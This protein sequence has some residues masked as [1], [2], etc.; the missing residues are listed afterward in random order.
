MAQIRFIL[1]SKTDRP[2]ANVML[3]IWHILSIRAH[4]SIVSCHWHV[5]DEDLGFE[6][7]VKSIPERLIVFIG[8][9]SLAAPGIIETINKVSGYS[10]KIV[11]AVP[12]DKAARSAIEDLPMGTA[13][14]T[15]GLNTISLKHS[16]VNSAIA[17]A[18]LANLMVP[19][20][21]RRQVAQFE[22]KEY[23]SAMKEEKAIVPKVELVDG[24]IPEK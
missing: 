21:E 20:G 6:A 17:V 4:V 1:G 7:F 2:N 11:F 23:L 18:K 3:A 8:G 13:L 19:P 22:L 24:L 14:L 15:S 12:T 9:M 5:G 10:D 16:L